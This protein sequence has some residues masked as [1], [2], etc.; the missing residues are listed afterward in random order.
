MAQPTSFQQ[1]NIDAMAN[2][3]N[4]MQ[5]LDMRWRGGAKQSEKVVEVKGQTSKTAFCF[6]H[7]YLTVE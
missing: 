2:Q 5:S 4:V 6:V 3:M 7:L 1:M